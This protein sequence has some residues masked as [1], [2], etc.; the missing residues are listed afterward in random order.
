MTMYVYK[1][2]ERCDEYVLYT[3]GLYDPQGEWHPESDHTS[4]EEA[5]KRVAWLNGNQA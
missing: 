2:T 3:V 4:A 1:E 5:A